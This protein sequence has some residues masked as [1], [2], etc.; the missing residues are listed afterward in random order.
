[1]A[2]PVGAPG[3]TV[4]A[5]EYV[6]GTVYGY[7]NEG[8]FFT[9]TLN[10]MSNLNVVGT[11]GEV[12]VDMAYNYATGMMYAIGSSENQEGPRTL[13]TVDLATGGITAVG[14]LDDTA[15]AAIMTLGITTEG[16]AYGISFAPGNQTNDSYLHTINLETAECEAIGPTGFPINYVQTM[17][18]DHNNDQMLWAQ[19][20]SDGMFTQTSALVAVN[21]ETGAGTQLGSTPVGGEVGELLGMFSVPG[22]GPTP[23]PADYTIEVGT[24]EANPGNRVFVP[25]SMDNLSSG[26]FTIEYDADALTYITHTNPVDD[27]FVVVN[28]WTPGTL[29]I[30][31]VNPIANYEGECMTLEFA[32]AADAEGTYALDL[33]VNDGASIVDEITVAVAGEDIE[34]IDGAIEVVLGYTVTFNYMVDGEWVSESQTVAVGEAAIAPEALPQAHEIT[35]LILL[36]WDVDFSAV[37]SDLEVTAEYGLLGDVYTDEEL[38]VSDALLIMRSVAG[39]ESLSEIQELLGDVDQD[40][41][42]TIVDALYLVRLIVGAESFNG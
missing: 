39:M 34:A 31:V 12:I 3:A 24:V 38:N 16:E 29:Q 28:D 37:Y 32:V 23:P 18:Y 40:G 25:V 22:E 26:S 21:L 15:V 42:V 33:T 20:Y 5:A 4:F 17:T 8:Q 1:M 30:A 41:D 11:I 7:T 36:G 6:D 19:F 35:Q 2:A 13:Y 10:N 9:T 27:T 14:S